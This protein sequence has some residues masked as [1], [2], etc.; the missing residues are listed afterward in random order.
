ME[1]DEE[2]GA[3]VYPEKYNNR[4]FEHNGQYIQLTGNTHQAVPKEIIDAVVELKMESIE[5]EAAPYDIKADDDAVQFIGKKIE[6][7]MGN[8]FNNINR[9]LENHS[10]KISESIGLEDFQKFREQIEININ[11]LVSE[12]TK[13]AEDFDPQEMFKDLDLLNQKLEALDKKVEG[14][15]HLDGADM[16]PTP[17]DPQLV[18]KIVHGELEAVHKGLPDIVKGIVE[19]CMK[20]FIPSTTGELKVAPTKLTLGQLA[21]LKESGYSVDEIK[22]LKAEGLI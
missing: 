16:R 15:K 20:T 14:I 3:Y 12:G 2:A 1:R 5:I 13:I 18:Q 8:A 11:Q 7:L 21:M 19:E 4:I 9:V 17:M 10:D 6:E 22:E